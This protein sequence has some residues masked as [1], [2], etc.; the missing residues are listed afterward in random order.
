MLSFF[1]NML[2][3]LNDRLQNQNM[4]T[5]LEEWKLS[6]LS[7]STICWDAW[8]RF[9]SMIF[10]FSFCFKLI[11]DSSQPKIWLWPPSK[12]FLTS[13]K[14]F[15]RFPGSSKGTNGSA[16]FQSE[17]VIV[18]YCDFFKW[19]FLAYLIDFWYFLGCFKNQ[20]HTNSFQTSNFIAFY[21]K[22]SKSFS[23]KTSKK[24]FKQIIRNI[25]K[26]IR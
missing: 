2:S 15:I 12:K 10:Y 18:L 17:F 11:C 13:Q 7:K 1:T 5:L 6:P 8:L 24:K 23:L 14:I 16:T 21:V 3:F 4:K 9:T 19:H 25:E 20:T 26:E 22:G